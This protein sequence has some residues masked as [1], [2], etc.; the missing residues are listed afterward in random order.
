MSQFDRQM[1]ISQCSV[2][3]ADLSTNA[4]EQGALDAST[5]FGDQTSRAAP[6]IDGLACHSSENNHN[7]DSGGNISSAPQN[8]SFDQEL[9]NLERE[10]MNKHRLSTAQQVFSNID[11]FSSSN[12]NDQ[13]RGQQSF[14]GLM[15]STNANGDRISPPSTSRANS[16]R[17]TRLAAGEITRVGTELGPTRYASSTLPRRILPT[18]PDEQFVNMPSLPKQQSSRSTSN[19]STL[20][21]PIINNIRLGA[22]NEQS[23]YFSSSIDAINRELKELRRQRMALD[24]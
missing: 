10:A 9:A 5:R 18:L 7:N 6:P 11:R 15:L 16:L 1:A 19:P 12:D 2:E 17:T 22:T 24:D 8:T 13:I 23:S 20:R 3:G 4:L 21:R 14:S